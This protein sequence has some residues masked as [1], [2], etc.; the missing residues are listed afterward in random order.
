MKLL[1]HPLKPF[2]G[3]RPAT[4]ESKS[5]LPFERNSCEVR[6]PLKLMRIVYALVIKNPFKV[7]SIDIHKLLT[8]GVFFSW[9]IDGTRRDR[10]EWEEIR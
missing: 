10:R 9:R 2:P 4:L 6:L 5:C 8:S 1:F 3:R 7:E